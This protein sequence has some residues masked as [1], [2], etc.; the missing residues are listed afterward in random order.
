MA[1][2]IDEQLTASPSHTKLPSGP[3]ALRQTLH[4]DLGGEPA[5]ITYSLSKSHNIAFQAAGGPV[6]QIQVNGQIPGGAAERTD[7]IRLVEIGGGTGLA[8]VTIKQM[9]EAENTVFDSVTLEIQN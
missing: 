8:Q 2:L 5:K 3:I 6:K 9:I 1:I 7:T 4:S